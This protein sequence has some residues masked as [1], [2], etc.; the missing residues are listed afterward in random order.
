MVSSIRPES[1]PLQEL[2]EL[3][4]DSRPWVSLSI[5]PSLS[6]SPE[7]FPLETP[8]MSSRLDPLWCPDDPPEPPLG[9][10]TPPD[11]PPCSS[12]AP[13]AWAWPLLGLGELKE[14]SW[15]WSFSSAV[16]TRPRAL[17]LDVGLGLA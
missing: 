1:L 9:D 15:P 5:P 2:R 13:G 10:A 4:V 11:P 8:S 16:A 3:R 7:S 17:V 12:W 14:A 6:L